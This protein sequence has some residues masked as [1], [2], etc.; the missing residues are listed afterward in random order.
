[1]ELEVSQT[2]VAPLHALPLSPHEHMRQPVTVVPEQMGSGVLVLVHWPCWLLQSC[3]TT[4]FRPETVMV[5][6]GLPSAQMSPTSPQLLS[7]QPAG[8]A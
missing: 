1:L 3:W 5:S 8:Y 2:G 4:H 6:P 7:P